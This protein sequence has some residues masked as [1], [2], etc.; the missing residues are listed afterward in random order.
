MIGDSAFD[1]LNWHD[2]LLEEKVVPVAP[3]ISGTP[4]IRSISNIGSKTASQSISTTSVFRRHSS[5]RPT[6]T[7]HRKRPRLASAKRAVSGALV[8]K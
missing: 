4:M 3:Y 2:M 5:T 8:P 6:L 7:D 1:I